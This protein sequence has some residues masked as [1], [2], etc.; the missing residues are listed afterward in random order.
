MREI[1]EG[2][3][4]KGGQNPPRPSTRRPPPPTGSG[5]GGGDVIANAPDFALTR[6]YVRAEAECERQELRAAVSW[7]NARLA[8]LEKRE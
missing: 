6:A 1:H 4:K 3:V 2:Y 7:I 5:G 8:A